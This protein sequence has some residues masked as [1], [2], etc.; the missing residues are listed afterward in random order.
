MQPG[1]RADLTPNFATAHRSVV[2]PSHR[3]PD[4]PDQA[5]VPYGSSHCLGIALDN[6]HPQPPTGRGQRVSET[7]DSSSDHSKI[8]IARRIHSATF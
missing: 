8:I 3:L 2:A 7:D 4:G 1:R 5:E 6:N